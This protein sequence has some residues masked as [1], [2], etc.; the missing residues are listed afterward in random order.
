MNIDDFAE[1]LKIGES[2][3]TEFKSWNKVSDMK[4][5]INLAV[6]E[7]IAFAN[8]KGGTLYFGVEDNGEVTGCDGNYDLQNIIESIYEKTRPSIFVDPEEIEYNG[9]KVIALTVASDGI[10]HATTDGRCLKRLGKNSKPFYPDEMSNRYSEIQ[11][12][13]FSGR[14]LSDSTEDD[15]NKLEVYKLKEKLKARNP[16]STLADMDDIAFLRDLALVKSDSGN[17]KLTVAGLL[18]VGKEQAIN[19]LLPQA[20]VIY[21]HYSESNL[22]EY[23]ARLDMKAPIIS[24]IDRLS[25]KI[26]D[27]NRIVNV[28]VGLFRL[29]IVDF[30]EKVFQEALLNALSH[31]DYQSQGAVYVKHYPDKIV[32]ENPGAFLDGITENNIITHPSV[33]RNKLI[34]ETL[35]HLKYVQRTGQGV[36]IIFREM[37]SSGKPFPEY[38]SYN[39]AVSLTIYSAIDDIDFVKFIAN[40]ENGLSRSFSL[41]E[42]MILRYLKDNRKITMSE[43]ETLIQEARDQ[44]QNACNN[45]KRYGLIE[46]S[47]NEYMLTAKIYDELKNPVD[48]TKD[49]AIQYIKAREMILE[50]IRDRGF[51]NNELVRELCGFSQKQARIILQRM[52]KENLIELSEKGRYAKYIIKK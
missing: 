7:L 29:E 41:S 17:I 39:D 46:L 16:E 31:R 8:N 19:R 34:A 14:I 50:Y 3:N 52:R 28:Q 23:D 26:Q 32:I 43:A 15:I 48:Y 6:D 37:I 13:D 24:V 12:S 10:I 38:K 25:E 22:E 36:D 47:G 11:S 49:K 33:P 44:A 20:E 35:Q 1:I 42:L 45:L 51:I 9:K 27:S 2:I 18:F 21:L 40:E 4:K 5:R 30:P